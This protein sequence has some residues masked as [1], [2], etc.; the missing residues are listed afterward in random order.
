ML[1]L[2]WVGGFALSSGG[3]G[4]I[5]KK[6]GLYAAMLS[7]V[8]HGCLSLYGGRIAEGRYKRFLAEHAWRVCLRCGYPLNSL[9]ERFRCPECGLSYETTDVEAKRPCAI[10]SH[11][12][13]T[14]ER[15]S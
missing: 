4:G 9:P 14:R 10:C 15:V 11:T 12:L 1:V 13:I 7:L 2:V 3:L 5:A 6:Y 8:L